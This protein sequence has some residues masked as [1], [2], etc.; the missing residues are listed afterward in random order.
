MCLA[1]HSIHVIQESILH[2]DIYVCCLQNWK[3][4]NAELVKHKKSLTCALECKI[5][6][7]GMVVDHC[8]IGEK[9]SLKN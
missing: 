7:W 3:F 5:G 1:Y 9:S 8:N 4:N 2:A 6:V